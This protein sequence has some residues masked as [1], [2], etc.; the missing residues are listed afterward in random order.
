MKYMREKG[1]QEGGCRREQEGGRL[2]G[3]KEERGVREGDDAWK[4]PRCHHPRTSRPQMPKTAKALLGSP[5]G[6]LLA[7]AWPV[8]ASAS[9]SVT[10][11]HPRQA[12]SGCAHVHSAHRLVSC[13]GITPGQYPFGQVPPVG[14]RV[15][16]GQDCASG[17]QLRHFTS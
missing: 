6:T 9:T 8:M 14:P 10:S 17:E 3:E 4:R 15:P 16:T 2:K 11:P 7:L 13:V 12:M 5:Q 1:R